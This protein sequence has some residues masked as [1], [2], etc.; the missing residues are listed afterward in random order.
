MS[1][2]RLFAVLSAVPLVLAATPVLHARN[3]ASPTACERNFAVQGSFTAGRTYSTEADIPGATYP[4][5]LY[6]IRDKLVEQ[7]LEVIA[8]QEKNGYI[9]A[10]NAV[11]GGEGG[12]ANAPLRGYVTRVD[13]A[14]VNVSLQF[15][16]AG[17][18]MANKK[19]VMKYLC[20]A[21]EAAAG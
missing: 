5:A 13:D 10:N 7:G 2:L 21:V 12:T 16:I 4:D 17:G 9:R 18:Q 6:R 20:D 14:S 3:G 1:T 15:T 19:T 11:R 8:V